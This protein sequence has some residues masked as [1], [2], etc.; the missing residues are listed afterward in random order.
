MNQEDMFIQGFAFRNDDQ[1]FQR[2]TIDQHVGVLLAVQSLVLVVLCLIFLVVSVVTISAP[3]KACIAEVASVRDVFLK[4][5]GKEKGPKFLNSFYVSLISLSIVSLF[6]ILLGLVSLLAER[7]PVIYLVD[8]ILMP[9]CYVYVAAICIFC[10][11]VSVRKNESS[12]ILVTAFAKARERVQGKRLLAY[13]TLML[14]AVI[15]YL[16]YIIM[17][18]KLHKMVWADLAIM[19]PSIWLICLVKQ[20]KGMLSHIQS[21]SKDQGGI[22]LGGTL[23]LP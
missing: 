15:I 23:V 8:F 12:G 11:V 7:F 5:G 1:I 2:R 3:L 20:L 22:A 14:L 6:L 9:I 13:A 17:A 16:T 21:F 10:L 4:I 19:I 18:A